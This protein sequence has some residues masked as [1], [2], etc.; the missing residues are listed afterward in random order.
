MGQKPAC[1]PRLA[2]AI[3]YGV[4]YDSTSS[5]Y[6]KSS[7]T[8][9]LRSNIENGHA[10]C[11]WHQ[12]IPSSS[13]STGSHFAVRTRFRLPLFDLAERVVQ[14][15]L[16]SSLAAELARSVPTAHR[17]STTAWYNSSDTPCRLFWFAP[18]IL[19]EECPFVKVQ[20][21]YG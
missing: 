20:L 12:T 8:H 14:H 7:S 4:S 9:P 17:E 3:E 11:C 13:L 16:S 6:D 1:C 18:A 5:S 19:L 10:D 2:I 21:F 15:Y